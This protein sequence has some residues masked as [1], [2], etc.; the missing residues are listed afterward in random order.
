MELDLTNLS[1]EPRWHKFGD[2]ELLIRPYPASMANFEMDGRK[3]VISGIETC[4]VFKYCL[5]DWKNVV[6]PEGKP[7]PCTDEVKQKVYDFRLAAMADFVLARS[8]Q[9]AELKE[10][11]E[12]NSS[13]GPGGPSPKA[14]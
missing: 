7:L 10:R 3:L 14:A 8:R 5:V 1:Y 11:A 6:D 13:P 4:E 12:K 9:F 2:C